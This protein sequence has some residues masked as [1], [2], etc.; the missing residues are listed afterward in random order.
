MS[1]ILARNTELEWERVREQGHASEGRQKSR[2]W[3]VA[4]LKPELTEEEYHA[5]CRAVLECSAAFDGMRRA[6]DSAPVDG[7][8]RTDY[9]L[10]ARVTAVRRLEGLRQAVRA[11]VQQPLAS[12]CVEWIAQLWTLSE[13]AGSLG[14]MRYTGTPRRLAPDTRL[15]KPYVRLVLM[16]MGNYFEGIDG[17]L[18]AWNEKGNL[19]QDLIRAPG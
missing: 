12:N 6:F 5:G 14:H 18:T 2:I 7:G 13:I 15:T 9:G 4:A 3:A 10:A 1:Q 8:A 16:A 11:R 17:D 19:G